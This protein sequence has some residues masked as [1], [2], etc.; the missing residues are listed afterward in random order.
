MDVIK[1]MQQI[2][3]MAIIIKFLVYYILHMATA[4]RS[5]SGFHKSIGMAS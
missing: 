5:L 4:N 2:R 3:E 1:Q